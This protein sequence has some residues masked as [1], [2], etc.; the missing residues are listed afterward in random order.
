TESHS[1]A[2]S[3]LHGRSRARGV[4]RCTLALAGLLFGL[5][6][7][8]ARP[9]LPLDGTEGLVLTWGRA[10][11]RAELALAVAPDETTDGRGAVHLRA[12]AATAEGNHYFGVMIPLPR[13][14]DLSEACLLL[15]ART[16]TAPRTRAFYLRA[17]NRGDRE[18]C[19]SFSSWNGLLS[20]NWTTFHFQQAL[21]PQGLSWEAKVVGDRA[22]TAVD[23]VEVL[24]GTSEDEADVDVLLDNLRLG[25]K[26]GTLAELTGVRPF[27]DGT[28][29][30]RDGAA[31]AV[32]LHPATPDGEAAAVAIAAAVR[33]RTGVDLPR[34]PGTAADWQPGENAI[35]IG[36]LDSNPALTVL[37]A[38]RLTPVD[39]V[40]PGRGG[41]LVHTVFDPFG[42][43]RN[44]VV[45]GAVDGDGSLRATGILI[46]ALRQAPFEGGVLALP[47]LFQAAYG[48]DFLAVCPWAAD[49]AA[50]DRLEKGL[51]E[52]QRA[53]DRG[54]HCSI[55]SVLSSVANRYRYTAHGI[56]ARLFVELWKLYAASAV[57]DPRKYG[58][59]WGF[60]SDFP[61]RD[62]V[63]G[64][65]IIE[66][67]PGLTD[68]DRLATSK[69]MGR[70]LAEAVIPKCAGAASSPHVPHNHQTFPGLG[71]LFAGLYFT[72]HCDVVE[73][74]LWL[75]LADGLFRRQAGFTKPYE[76][77]NGYQWLT[78]GHLLVYAMARPDHTV[79]ANGNA[80]RLV[81]YCIGTMDN[82]GYQVPYGDTGTWRCWNSEMICLD[83]VACATGNREA[84]WAANWK[85]EIKKT[86]PAPG[87]FFQF[88]T[89]P[90]PTRYDGVRV[91]PLE[92]A[93]YA[94]FPADGRPDL[95]HCF[96]KISFRRSIDPMT[97]YLL[98]DGL[99]NGGHKHLDGNSIPRITLFDRIWLADNDYFKAPLKYHNSLLVIRNGESTTIP[100]YARLISAG[101]S[102]RFG[103]SRT[104]VDDYA[105]VDWERA[106]VWLKERDAFVVLDTL[107]ARQAGSYQFRLLWHGVGEATLDPRGLKLAQQGP[108]LWIQVAPGPRLAMVDDE[109]LGAN[110][111]GYPY[112]PPV[113]RSLTATAG[114]ALAEG[115]RYVFATVIQGSEAG[116]RGPWKVDVLRDAAGALLRT[117]TGP[118]AL[119]LGPLSLDTADGMLSTDARVIV[120]DGGGVSFLGATFAEAEGETLH[121]SA[122]PASVDLREIDPSRSLAEVPLRG[123]APADDPGT[124]AA[125][126]PVRWSTA[127][128]PSRLV[129]TGNPGAGGAIADFARVEVHPGPAAA[130]V[131]NPDAANRADALLDGTWKTT[132][133]SVMFEPN[134]TVVITVHFTAPAE[135][136][137]VA[138]EQWWAATSSRKT[139]YQLQRAEA[140]VSSD[141]FAQDIR[142]L[143][144]IEEPGEHP[145]WG[146]PVSFRIEAEGV[147][148]T[149]VRL[150]LEPRPDTAVYLGEVTVEGTTDAPA[151]QT[152]RYGITAVAGAR[153]Q[154]GTQR[155]L[156][157][158]TAQGDLLA[159]DPEGNL[160]W[161]CPVGTRLND[162]IASDL[163]ADGVDEIV[164]A[165]QDHWVDVR[166]ADGSLLWQRE[167]PYYRRPPHVNLVRSGDLD[168]DGRPE[169][170][171]GGENWRFYAFAADGR[172]LWHYEAVHPARSGAVA[173]LDG[174]GCCEVLCGTHYYTMTVLKPDGTRKW[175]AGFGPICR[176]L[177]T[178]DWDGGGKR[179]VICGSGDGGIYLFDQN[180]SRRLAL[181]TGD[182][183]VDVHAA[184]LDRDG[185]DEALAAGL[186]HFLYCCDG[187][188]K[189]L[190]RR[191]LGA[192]VTHVTTMPVAGECRILAATADGRVFTLDAGGNILACSDLG[193]RVV[194]WTPFEDDFVAA[195]AD[196]RISCLKPLP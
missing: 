32:I 4:S 147:T 184:D 73:G 63:A 82:L 77:C 19:W 86:R 127:L 10:G 191:D 168:G 97:P 45:V 61:S 42:L 89:A 84:L 17:Y 72:Q 11:A 125:A 81:D 14:V 94:T 70:W 98:L 163:D 22:A 18:P 78:N 80:G 113:V 159:L 144:T 153:L 151:G 46:E 142:R 143:G 116:T 56:E 139:A 47:R 102:S 74:E 59:P 62:V 9:L 170:V 154:P 101:E 188:G 91:W 160:L 15:D 6:A 55:A 167:L 150:V 54:Q 177:T 76:D 106:I 158:G 126:H 99:S 21:S 37:Y 122:Q 166:R 68:A 162:A 13:P 5:G 90:V 7:T 115:E 134:A 111:V 50:A 64:W 136:R 96:D 25:P 29:L 66:E 67:D 109:E 132:T 195:T 30:V 174:D 8:P 3:C 189:S 130:N 180:G 100:P 187:D 131:F 24:V 156:V 169:I 38:R 181:N 193:S 28:V 123:V 137:A 149:A 161:T 133:D 196:G 16:T 43:G 119:G 117:P 58:G 164:L 112:A 1:A 69:R 95:E 92:P 71:A 190:W 155:S 186:S 57:A 105:G 124:A 128:R 35:L 79:F 27:V 146:A 135:I 194:G 178:G 31:A 165:R 118:L 34:R 40:C 157:V 49:E 65:D 121:A 176:D 2:R 41:A 75:R 48:E 175:A 83:I 103:Y 26:L 39:S 52:G 185:N 182:E 148:A 60:D 183:V 129:L 44:V 120:A 192:A 145:D 33:E 93:Y 172:E 152:A 23:R 140:S 20:P 53:L 85:R 104:R 110:W 87:E 12:R 141:G 171:A 108:E 179:G 173:D 36:C 114:G 51:A 107:E 88:G 138:W